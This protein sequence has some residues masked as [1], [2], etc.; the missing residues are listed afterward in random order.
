MKQ[1]ILNIT[2]NL[3]I[4]TRHMRIRREEILE[5]FAHTY[6]ADQAPSEDTFT[7]A[8]RLA[9]ELEADARTIRDLGCL[10]TGTLKEWRDQVQKG[11]NNGQSA[12]S[13]R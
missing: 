13:S 4:F 11:E 6:I 2:S 9:E 8:I 3:N 12:S 1:K 5:L 7:E 10:L